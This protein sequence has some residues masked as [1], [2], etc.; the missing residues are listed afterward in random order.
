M[1]LNFA[2][3]HWAWDHC[4]APCS[5]Q[6]KGSPSLCDFKYSWVGENSPPHHA[7]FIKSS[8]ELA[9]PCPL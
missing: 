1:A 9:A 8:E 3:K 2:A 7:G 5:V 6:P 4:G